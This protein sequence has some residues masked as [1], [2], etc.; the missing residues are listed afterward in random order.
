[1]TKLVSF[2][3][4]FEKINTPLKENI[5]V[6]EKK[7]VLKMRRGYYAKKDLEKNARLKLSD[8]KYVRPAGKNSINNLNEILDKKIKNNIKK[9]DPIVKKVLR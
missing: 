6:E 7:N 3:K 2:F 4:D 9:D 5:S 8:I 1:M